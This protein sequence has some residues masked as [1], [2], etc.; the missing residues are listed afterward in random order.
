MFFKKMLINREKEKTP[1]ENFTTELFVFILTYLIKNDGNLAK[2]ILNEFGFDKNTN[3]QDL[4]IYTQKEFIACGK[5]VR[6]DIII[7]YNEELTIIEVKV[8]SKLNN[9]DIDKKMLDQIQ[10]YEKIKGRKNV[11]LLSKYIISNVTSD[12]RILWSSIY[13]LLEKNSNDFVVEC[14]LSFLKEYGM[15]SVKLTEDI[16][17][18]IR[19]INS[20]KQLIN[21][22]WGY[23][24]Y[25]L[26]YGSAPKNEWIGFYVKS[27]MGKNKKTKN[28][29]WIGISGENDTLA[30]KVEDDDLAKK[31]AKKSPDIIDEYN[32]ISRKKL[33]EIIGQKDGKEQ[34]EKL[35]YWFKDIME[36]R[37]K[38]FV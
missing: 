27:P 33:K 4:L 31:I 20:F 23:H 25:K 32:I 28:L 34:K 29:F 3:L 37:L 19:T 14:F 10:L 36:N 8:N 9:Y 12:K 6:P 30:F 2:K 11:Y 5:P 35:V 17:S 7:D 13:Y 24:N 21:D 15:N 16:L 1:L 26:V 22:A 38:G 18:L